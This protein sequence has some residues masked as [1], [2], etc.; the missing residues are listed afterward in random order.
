MM[1]SASFV[2]V[3]IAL[4]LGIS[5]QA[6]AQKPYRGAEY[7]TIGTMTYGRFEV[8]M[9]SAPVS[10]M[11]S[12]FFTYYDP[13]SPWN[14]IDV[15]TMGRYSNEMQFNT[16]VPTQADN[17]VQRQVV[18]FNPHAGFH[19][20]G[21]EW[22]PDYVAWRVDGEEVYRQLG[23]H[24]ALLT[25]PQ[26]IMMNVWQPSAVD[27]A[28]TFS[29][30]Q[31]PVYA[32]YDWVKYYAYT[33]GSGDNFILQWTDDFL[34]FDASRWQ[35]AAHTWDGNN[36]QFVTDNAVIQDGYL[37]LCLTSN[38]TSGYAGGA[39]P[40]EDVDPPSLLWARA[41]DSTLVVRFSE[42]VSAAT[43]ENVA[44]YFGGNLTYKNAKLRADQRTIDIAVAGLDLATPFILFGQNVQDQASSPNT[45]G[46]NHV[47]V[48]MPLTFPIRIDVGGN[49]S[50][51]YLADSTWSASKEY[52]GIGGIG[53]SVPGT[54]SI[55]GTTEPEV[56]RSIVHGLAGYTVRVPNGTYNVSLKMVEN[57]YASV[58]KRVF[59]AKIQGQV[60]FTDLDLF[61][62]VGL[63]T[64]YDAVAPTVVVSDNILNIWMGASVDSTTLSGIVI[65]RVSGPTGMRQSSEEVPQWGFSV[66][67]NPYNGSSMV[68]FSLPVAG[69]VALQVH[70][71]LGRQVASVQLGVM[72]AGTHEYRWTND[73]L[74]SGAYFFT[75]HE[76]DRRL[77]HRIIVMR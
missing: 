43:A 1:K 4:A 53:V 51:G 27:W 44:N 52:G 58:G 8:R 31:L 56:Y 9:R 39:I 6:M 2:T 30:S 55:A 70:D 76:N 69:S 26:K 11:L 13:A 68:R 23:S 21:I 28:G 14:E 33:P 60:L 65:E 3:F 35:K 57:R 18:P 7:R 32:Y 25:E 16:I 61:Q 72:N 48:I 77:T 12:S 40:D 29:A 17:H 62:Q 47:R 34:T 36:A 46:L 49:G 64:A 5:M 20:I 15:E 66:Y 54:L 67:P 59:S 24:I 10:G 73:R 42:P 38:T 75:L 74:A 37:I 50:D 45:M 41:Y 22:T 71:T 63:L 19:I